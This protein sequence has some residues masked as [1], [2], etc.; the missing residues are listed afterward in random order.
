VGTWGLIA[1]IASKATA[2]A[3]DSTDAV[4]TVNKVC[5]CSNQWVR[6]LEQHKQLAREIVDCLT[7][8]RI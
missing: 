8:V 7:L 1:D 6:H 4:W 5:G 2:P 3:K